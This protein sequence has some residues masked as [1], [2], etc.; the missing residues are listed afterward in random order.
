MG[1]RLANTGGLESVDL[2]Y[3]VVKAISD[4]EG[5]DP[6]MLDRPLHDAIDPDALNALFVGKRG[7]DGTVTFYY[8]GYDV[9]VMRD[10][11]VTLEKRAERKR[12]GEHDER[13]R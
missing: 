8:H 6:A 2:G 10:G 9:T 3:A 1:Y 12:P 13:G 5:T 7:T 4:A 11:R